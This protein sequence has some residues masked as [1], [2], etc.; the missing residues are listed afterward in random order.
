S[1]TCRRRCRPTAASD[2]STPA[3]SRRRRT[4]APA[5]ASTSR[6]SAP[7]RR[8]PPGAERQAMEQLKQALAQLQTKFS[9]LSG[10]E[11]KMVLA[12]VP[13]LLAVTLFVV[14]FSF[15]NSANTIRKRTENKQIQL[16]AVRE[17]AGNFSQAEARRR[18]AEQQL[19]QSNVR[20]ISTLEQKATQNGLVIPSMTPR[21]ETKLGDGRILESRV[22]LTLADVSV[23]E[24]VNFLDSV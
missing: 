3:A 14:I 24:V 13:V 19:G 6:S 8:Q 9:A 23:R 15:S 5:S 2:R 22:D 11:Q 1:T 21:G 16:N 10:R 12:L 7:P 4:T 17:L 18:A 20:L